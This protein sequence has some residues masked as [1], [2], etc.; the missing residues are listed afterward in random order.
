MR[1]WLVVG[2]VAVV[3]LAGWLYWRVPRPKYPPLALEPD[4]PMLVDAVNQA[5]ATL[6]TFRDM[7]AAPHREAQ[8]KV[9]FVTSSGTAEFL[10]AEVLTLRDADVD[11]RLLTPPVTHTGKV[12]RLQTFPVDQLQDWMVILPDGKYVGG[13]SMRV[14]FKRGRELW[15]SLPPELEA[16]E[17]KYQR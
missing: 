12:E 6:A 14:L 17:R 16:E 7:V 5:K 4:D 11:V 15:G 3:T 13:Y 8:V 2:T 9:P 1:V 10:W